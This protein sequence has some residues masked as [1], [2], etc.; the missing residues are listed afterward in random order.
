[1]DGC[2]GSAMMLGAAPTTA[3]L[4]A[5]CVATCCVNR[6]QEWQRSV[7]GIKMLS[8]GTDHTVADT[9]VVLAE[10]TITHRFRVESAGPNSTMPWMTS[11][12]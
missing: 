4:H 11:A 2:W 6:K 12:L 9:A 1:M 8:S 10:G 7:H 3:V 5:A